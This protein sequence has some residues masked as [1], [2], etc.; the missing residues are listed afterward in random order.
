LGAPSIGIFPVGWA[1]KPSK[2][3]FLFEV[4]KRAAADQGW[5]KTQRILELCQNISLT[6]TREVAKQLSLHCQVLDFLDS[7][8][9]L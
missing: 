9:C 1:R 4:L 3:N 6:L 8:P 2:K 5:P 7:H